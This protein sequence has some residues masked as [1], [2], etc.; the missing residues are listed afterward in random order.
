MCDAF[1]HC[2][3]YLLKKAAKLES[4]I[5]CIINL[6]ITPTWRKGVKK[7]YHTKGNEIYFQSGKESEQSF[8][9]T[10]TGN[11]MHETA[12]KWK[13]K[14]KQKENVNG[15]NM[16]CVCGIAWESLVEDQE[17]DSLWIACAGKTCKCKSTVVCRLWLMGV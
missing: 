4:I 2:S 8:F 15:E 16:C 17:S 11:V 13:Q 10:S 5:G 9:D 7:R 14:E 6:E 1:Y 12:K 3:Y